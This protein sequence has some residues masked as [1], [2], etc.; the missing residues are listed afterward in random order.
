MICGKLPSRP[1]S[2]YCTLPI[3]CGLPEDQPMTIKGPQPSIYTH[4]QAATGASPELQRTLHSYHQQNHWHCPYPF[5]YYPLK[6]PI[7]PYISFLPR[8]AF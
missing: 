4:A 3:Q 7:C 6:N 1:T 8:D 5:P 2:I